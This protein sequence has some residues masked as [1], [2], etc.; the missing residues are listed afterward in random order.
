MRDFG[1]RSAPGRARRHALR[2]VLAECVRPALRPRTGRRA[3]CPWT[4]NAHAS[5]NPS[6]LRRARSAGVRTCAD[7]SCSPLS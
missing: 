2:P 5:A 4:G 1:T 6:P 7:T 3:R